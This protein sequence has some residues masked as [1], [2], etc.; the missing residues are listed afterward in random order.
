[1]S[2]TPNPPD[3]NAIGRWLTTD[4]VQELAELWKL[5]DAT[6]RQFVGDDVHLRGLVEV[7]NRC[8]RNCLYCG[9]RAGNTHLQRYLM[10]AEEVVACARKA[11]EVGFGTLVLQAG[12]DA[13]IDGRWMADIIRQVKAETGL[14]IT[15]SLGERNEQDY[16]L[17]REAGADRYLLRFETGNQRLFDTI[18]PPL[19]GENS[20]RLA[21]LQLLR[22][23]GYEVGSGVMVGFLGRALRPWRRTSIGFR[24]LDLDMIR[25]GPYIPH[26]DT[27]LARK[28]ERLMLPR[29]EQVP[30]RWRWATECWHWPTFGLPAG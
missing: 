10:T 23:V 29:G 21:I 15:L 26:P 13:G 12:E 17:W 9:I 2:H 27:T 22:E 6:R 18:H 20:D 25:V 8:A 3:I 30:I 7:S 24:S 4:D 1:M 11:V 19:P 28:G 5:A 16:R 14:A